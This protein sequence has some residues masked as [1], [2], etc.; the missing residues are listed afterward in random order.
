MKNADNKRI[1]KN[2]L[3]LYFRMLFAMAVG[4]YTSRVVLNTLGVEDFGI[5]NVVGGLVVVL[6]FLNG[7]M[8]GATQRYLNIE[9][10]CKN[11]DRLKKVFTTS[12]L[13][14]FGVSI[15]IF[16]LAETI[17]LWFLNVHLSIAPERMEAANWVYQFSIAAFIVSVISVPY[18]ATIIAHEKMSAFAYIGIFEVMIKLA[19]VLVLTVSPFDKLIFYAFLLFVVSV[20]IR[21]IYGIYCNRKFEECR[22]VSWKIEKP[23][24]KSMISF[25]SWTIVGN[26]G[27]I[28]HTQG[29]AIVMN[30]FFGATVNA[31][32]GIA[33]QVNV[34]VKGFVT[35]FLQALNPQVVK[36]YAANE[37]KAMHELI[38]RGC[39]ISSY[40][41]AFL[42]IPLILE[43]PILLKV[44]L[45]EVPE[46]TIIFV[47]LVLLL[48]LFDS[49]TTLLGTAKGATGN[50]KIYQITLTLIGLFHLPFSAL[51]FYWGYPPYYAMY[52]YLVIVLTL[53]IFRIF[54][55]CNAIG[56]SKSLFFKQVVLRCG[57]VLAIAICLPLYIHC[58]VTPSLGN[59]F[60]VAVSSMVSIA[61][62]SLFL[63]FSKEDRSKLL[64]KLFNR[65]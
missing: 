3:L 57:L 6:S 23:L 35:N 34:V 25:S 39:Q 19:V 55:V 7:A 58:I 22:I 47:R 4:L 54:F 51:F 37:M 49:F 15:V 65:K 18:N 42:A 33:N 32:Q 56:L 41:V 30:L 52:V 38:I 16:L 31:A 5:Y 2:T 27:Y 24:L 44:W 14:H 40:L 10:G 63:G 45:K 50:I 48:S 46:Y 62:I 61:I 26:L 13:I 28:C 29:I 1:A 36:T 43:T 9:L 8:A 20:I 17:G 60:L 59:S 12:L 21:F 64:Y 53:Q 11:Y